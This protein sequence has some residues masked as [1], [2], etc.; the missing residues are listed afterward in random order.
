MAMTIK[1]LKTTAKPLEKKIKEKIETAEAERQGAIFS[2]AGLI[3]LPLAAIIDIID[4]FIASILILDII[5]ILTIG[6]WIY[7]RSQQL[8]VTRGGGS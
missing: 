7:F 4:F 6:V 3:M 5:A 1:S 2:P 8:K